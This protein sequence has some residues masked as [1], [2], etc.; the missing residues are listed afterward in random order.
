VHQ[1]TAKQ[2]VS[3]VFFTKKTDYMP[4][5]KAPAFVLPDN[6]YQKPYN[7]YK[8]AHSVA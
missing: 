4:T 2:P 1:K 6:P 7:F 3:A 8:L 5:A